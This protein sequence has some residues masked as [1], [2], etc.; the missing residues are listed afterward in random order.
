MLQSHDANYS[1]VKHIISQTQLSV[2]ATNTDPTMSHVDPVTGAFHK[3]QR[4]ADVGEPLRG[5]LADPR[6]CSPRAGQKVPDCPEK[7][8]PRPSLLPHTARASVNNIWTAPNSEIKGL[9]LCNN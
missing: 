7:G 1:M 3:R 9:F 2:G 5:D 8:G 6:P 4:R